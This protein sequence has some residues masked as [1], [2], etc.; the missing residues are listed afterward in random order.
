MKVEADEYKFRQLVTVLDYDIVFWDPEES[1]VSYKT[2]SLR[3]EGRETL[4]IHESA[5]ATRTIDWRTKEFA[6]FLA[7]GRTLVV[8]LPPDITRR[9]YTGEEETSGTGRNRHVKKLTCDFDLMDALPGEWDWQFGAGN[10]FSP[11]PGTFSALFRATGD[12][13]N[14]TR[15]LPAGSD[16]EALATVQGTGRIAAG[17]TQKFGGFL[18]LLP[19][20]WRV[21]D[22]PIADDGDEAEDNSE[23]WLTPEWETAA[24]AQLLDWVLDFTRRQELDRPSWVDQYTLTSERERQAEI[25]RAKAL[26][27]QQQ[28]V[29]DDLAA[30][31]DDDQQWKVLLYGSGTVLEDQVRASFAELGFELAA[32]VPGRADIRGHWGSTD[33]VA[34]VKGIGKSA[35]EKHA[36]QLDKWV[37]EEKAA[38]HEVKGILVVTG[39]NQTPLR[40]RTEHI[41]PDQMLPY[42]VNRGH[43]LVS[44]PQLLA[45]VRTAQKDPARR[46]DLAK[47]LLSTVGRLEGWD[48]LDGILQF[49]QS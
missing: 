37:A 21:A 36:A 22:R 48:V 7:L 10:A 33:F 30:A 12:R 9:A 45:L 49:H 31:H 3:T 17:Y 43:C 38:D 4:G 25:D 32:T 44:G 41:F 26:I 24:D 39:W 16:L 1:I 35:G 11:V 6:E 2:E 40:E 5:T 13:Y 15:T 19:W 29:L 47:L 20:L 46:D 14:Y 42:A 34:E 8:F 27:A 23:E 28:A 18:I